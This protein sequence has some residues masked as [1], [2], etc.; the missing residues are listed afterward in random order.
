MQVCIQIQDHEIHLFA[1]NYIKCI[2]LNVG[3]ISVAY[4]NSLV[5]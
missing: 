2:L 3:H 5:I 1:R 4:K